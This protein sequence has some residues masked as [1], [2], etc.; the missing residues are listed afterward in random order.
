MIDLVD[1]ARL[2]T[3]AD[4]V[5]LLCHSG[6]WGTQE[7]RPRRT[8]QLRLLELAQCACRVAAAGLHRC[9]VTGDLLCDLDGWGGCG[10]W[11]DGWLPRVWDVNGWMAFLLPPPL[12]LPRRCC[13]RR[14]RRCCCFSSAQPDTCIGGWPGA[15]FLG[16]GQLVSGAK[17]PT[18]ACPSNLLP[19]RMQPAAGWGAPSWGRANSRMALSC[20]LTRWGAPTRSRT[21]LCA[22]WSR[23]ARR[24]RRRP[25]T[26][27]VAQQAVCTN[28]AGPLR[29]GGRLVRCRCGL[30]L[31]IHCTMCGCSWDVH[32]FA[33]VRASYG[34]LL[35]SPPCWR[36]LLPGEGHERRRRAKAVH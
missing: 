8:A 20:Q 31:S 24:T 22:L 19:Q 11:M 27:Q 25:P 18:D 5:D 6:G 7:I 21:P 14:R 32:A 28:W 35:P 30:I 29:L 1:T 33:H 17:L 16:Q 12:L 9:S 26:R 13:R 2:E 10:V 34:L 15:A 36:H 23:L 3:G 4:Q